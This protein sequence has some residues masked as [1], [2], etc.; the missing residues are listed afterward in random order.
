LPVEGKLAYVIRV[1][2][3]ATV[4]AAA[5]LFLMTADGARAVPSISDAVLTA[6]AVVGQEAALA[7]RAVDPAAPV[8]GFAFTFENGDRYAGSACRPQDSRGRA[9]GRPFRAGDPV[10]AIA[11]PT[12]EQPGATTARVVAFAGGCGTP[13]A[14]VEQPFTITA[15]N[16]G[17]PL[18]PLVAGVPLVKLAVGP[19]LPVLG[20]ILGRAAQSPCK[21]AD[22]LPVAGEE[23][24]ARRATLCLINRERASRGRGLVHSDKRLRRAAGRHARRMVRDGWF[25]H[26][27]PDGRDLL[28][29]MRFVRWPGRGRSWEVGEN[30]G[31]G[32]GAT[33]TPRGMVQSWMDSTA[34]RANLLDRRFDRLGLAIV[35][36]VPGD[37]H[38][39]ATYTTVYGRI[40]M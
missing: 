29:R 13:S 11:R 15:T 12:F 8:N 33:A 25:A 38:V 20:P 24:S 19:E 6:P 36:G 22:A 10:T 7:V 14:A 32:A 26:V 3:G 37:P 34:H 9:P 23:A 35:A 27:G 16:P 28:A 39:G 40:E 4:V 31:L 5:G 1:R 2:T 17:E 30:I 21:G 18:V